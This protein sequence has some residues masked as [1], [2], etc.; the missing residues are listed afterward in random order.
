VEEE[1]CSWARYK[2]ILVGGRWEWTV[3]SNDITRGAEIGG[4]MLAVGKA[5]EL[6]HST[7]KEG[8]RDWAAND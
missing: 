2:A 8:R 6:F 4:G 7:G 5:L 1:P 3:R